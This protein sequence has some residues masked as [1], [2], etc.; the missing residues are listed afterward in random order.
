MRFGGGETRARRSIR[1]RYASTSRPID[2]L[3]DQQWVAV[4]LTSRVPIGQFVARFARYRVT[5]AW[6]GIGQALRVSRCVRPS[7]RKIVALARR[8]R[9]RNSSS[10]PRNHGQSMAIRIIDKYRY[11]SLRAVQAVPASTTCEP[12]LRLRREKS[13]RVARGN[14]ADSRDIH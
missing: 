11:S 13:R 8:A 4:I 6:G 12:R 3:T 14:D 2:R 7:E 5:K 1:D 9:G 10:I